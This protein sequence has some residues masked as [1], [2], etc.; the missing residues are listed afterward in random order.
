MS[1]PKNE[2]A[3]F[4]ENYVLKA[5]NTGKTIIE[6]LQTSLVNVF[7]LLGDLPEEKHN[8]AYA[9]GKWT[10][11][12]L[13]LHLTDTERIMAYRALRISRNEKIN[14]PGFD[15][16][17]YVTNSNANEIPFIDLLKEFSLVRKSTIAMFRGF[18]DGMLIRMGNASDTPISVRAL[19][20][21][22]TGHVLHHLEI[23]EERY[24]S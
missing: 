2:F 18:N 22:L 9:E 6:N 24:L 20:C 4:Y 12:E 8:H 16:N 21:I 14:L 5:E 3:P 10:L 19:G 13:L 23:V 7:E 1:I 15:E 17:N 11:K